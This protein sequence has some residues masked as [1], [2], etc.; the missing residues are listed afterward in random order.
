[1]A[2]AVSAPVDSLPEFALGPD[3]LPE[4]VQEAAL[5]ED[6]VSVVDAPFAID[7]GFAASDTV[8][9]DGGVPLGLLWALSPLPPPP[10]AASARQMN[11]IA[12]E[13]VTIPDVPV[14]I[15]GSDTT[16][17][18]VLPAEGD[19]TRSA[20]GAVG[21]SASSCAVQPEIKPWTDRSPR[22]SWPLRL[23]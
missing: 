16:R 23:S 8:S 20:R 11:R 18:I 15:A 22:L 10:Q 4:A 13:R 6:Q 1:M 14:E 9:A 19:D 2:L 12:N 7:A 21:V 3:Q 5:D 17:S